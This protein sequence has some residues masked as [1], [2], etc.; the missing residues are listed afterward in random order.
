[1]RGRG[2]GQTEGRTGRQPWDG[3]SGH[4][5]RGREAAVSRVAVGGRS[6][7]PGRPGVGTWCRGRCRTPGRSRPREGYPD[8]RFPS[9][10]GRPAGQGPTVGRRGRVRP[11]NSARGTAASRARPGVRRKGYGRQPWWPV[12]SRC[13]R[14]RHTRPPPAPGS[15]ARPQRAGMPSASRVPEREGVGTSVATD[16]IDCVDSTR[17]PGRGQHE[18]R[19]RPTT[20]AR[21]VGTPGDPRPG[22]TDRVTDRKLERPRDRT[23]RRSAG[24]RG[25]RLEPLRLTGG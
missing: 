22:R 4:G 9:P 25:E 7:R 6:R 3:R 14:S 2:P 23:D 20:D 16:A 18:S 1:M 8:R 12:S 21:T 10:A 13:G 11:S 15:T 24:R 17:P 19:K 5:P